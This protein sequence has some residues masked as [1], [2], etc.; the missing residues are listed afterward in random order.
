[1]TI[2]AA[3]STTVG[4]LQLLLLAIHDCVQL[5]TGMRGLL[6]TNF[7]DHWICFLSVCSEQS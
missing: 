4:L 3:D 7:V 6:S 5:G 2:P 1:M